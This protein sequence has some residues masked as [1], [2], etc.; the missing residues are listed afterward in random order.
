MCPTFELLFCLSNDF[1]FLFKE[2]EGEEEQKEE[3]FDFKMCVLIKQGN[4]D[5]S[6]DVSDIKLLYGTKLERE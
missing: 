2:E 5:S 6:G 4:L 3:A 1:F